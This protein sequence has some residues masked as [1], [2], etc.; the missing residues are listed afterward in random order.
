MALATNAKSIQ[1]HGE[2]QRAATPEE[3]KL[4]K[5]TSRE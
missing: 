2:T 5:K 1:P 4:A 3:Q